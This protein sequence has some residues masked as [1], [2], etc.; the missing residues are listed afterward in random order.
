MVR[1]I[2]IG[3]QSES[4]SDKLGAVSGFRNA[5]KAGASTGVIYKMGTLIRQTSRMEIRYGISSTVALI[6]QEYRV[7]K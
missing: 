5:R 2:V 1:T 6:Y 7:G 3:H 4:A